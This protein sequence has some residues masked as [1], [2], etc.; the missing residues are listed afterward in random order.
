MRTRTFPLLVGL[1]TLTLGF[2]LPL[3]S[4][5]PDAEAGA[6]MERAS[7]IQ[8]MY[9]LDKMK[10]DVERVGII[11]KRGFDNQK[12]ML[13]SAKRAVASIQGKLYVGYVESKSDVAEQFRALTGEHNVQALWI[14]EE[15]GIVDASAPREYLIKNA[16]ES[17]I[18]LLAPSEDWV[19][20]GAPLAID[21]T[22]GE[23]QILLN[24]PAAKAT[25]LEV[26]AEHEGKTKF[27][28]AAN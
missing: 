14:V 23:I 24:E 6:A 10:P 9:F 1:A 15:D 28:A 20:E 8:Q 19:N 22:N 7:L 13:E 2:T 16:I 25:A 4:V 12:D 5:G 21:R 17:G 18:P 27:I 11:W 3:Q 26:P